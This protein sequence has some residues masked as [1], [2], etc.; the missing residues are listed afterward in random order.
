MCLI[1]LS[2]FCQHTLSV[3]LFLFLLRL[4]FGRAERDSIIFK[5]APLPL[6]W[7]H[8][9]K[10]PIQKQKS[11]LQKKCVVAILYNSYIKDIVMF[12]NCTA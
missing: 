7:Q 12:Q 3:D 9:N 6:L 4:R 11:L 5:R 2:T 1:I 10:T 8:C